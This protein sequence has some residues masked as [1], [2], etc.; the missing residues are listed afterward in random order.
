MP[1]MHQRPTIGELDKLLQ[2]PA[3]TAVTIRPNGSV[4]ALTN[5]EWANLQLG[6]K[7]YATIGLPYS[8]KSTLCSEYYMHNGYVVI[9]PDNFREA[10]HGQRFIEEAESFVWASVYAAVDALLLTHHKVI[11]DACNISKKRREPWEKRGAI[12]ILMGETEE[13]C[14]N[15]AAEENDSTIIPVIRR[16]AGECDWPK[17]I[18]NF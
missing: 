10:I 12:F 2:S 17:A 15:R 5:P 16:M 1:N 8:G 14:I 9:C 3:E 11:V 7:L 6:H 4:Q 18:G 13:T